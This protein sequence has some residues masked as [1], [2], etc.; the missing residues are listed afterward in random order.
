MASSSDPVSILSEQLDDSKIPIIKLKNTRKETD[1]SLYA[2]CF[3]IKKLQ[4]EEDGKN[5][6]GQIKIRR[7]RKDW[8]NSLEGKPLDQYIKLSIN[9]FEIVT[10]DTE[11]ANKELYGNMQTV[12]E[13]EEK[14]LKERNATRML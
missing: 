13:K 4:E 3:E 14:K 10:E 8:I 5:K 2:L 1:K 12:A 11:D 6:K 7:F 9:N